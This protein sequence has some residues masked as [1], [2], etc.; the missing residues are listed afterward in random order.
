MKATDFNLKKYFIKENTEVMES[1]SCGCNCGKA[2]CESC[3]KKNH[4]HEGWSQLPDMDRDK[5]QERDGLEG[6][7]MTKS[8]KVVY[9][10]PKE[11]S[12]YDPDTDI[13]LTHDEWKALDESYSDDF[14][15]DGNWIEDD[16]FDA[17]G[18]QGKALMQLY[19]DNEHNNYHSE[20]N[21]LLAKAFGTPKEV[22]MVELIIKKNQKQGHTSPEDSE[23]MYK[24]IN[25]P[26]YKQLVAGSL[27]EKFKKPT[28]GI[29]G[30]IGQGIDNIAVGGAKLAYKGAK[31]AVPHIK[32]GVKKLSKLGSKNTSTSFKN[33]KATTT[34]AYNEMS[35]SQMKRAKARTASLEK[36]MKKYGDAEKMGMDPARVNQ[37]RNAPTLTKRE[38]IFDETWEK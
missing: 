24:N 6:P 20:N 25:K 18:Q 34:T 3:G 38:S 33:G 26:Y 15:Y 10:D 36:T 30:A 31:K 23:W 17:E 1:C 22:N 11:G 29:V 8:G 5:Y 28:E 13:Y 32:K 21:L 7:I 9:Y 16:D 2:I 35:P 12:Y 37:R 19:K 14:D 4:T 27:S